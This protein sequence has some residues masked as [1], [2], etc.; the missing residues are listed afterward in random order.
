MSLTP[1]ALRNVIVFRF[2]TALLFRQH[3]TGNALFYT[4]RTCITVNGLTVC[5]KY[6]IR[7]LKEC[8]SRNSNSGGLSGEQLTVEPVPHTPGFCF[9]IFHFSF[10]KVPRSNFHILI[11]TVLIGVYCGTRTTWR[12]QILLYS[13]RQVE[14]LALVEPTG[15]LLFEGAMQG[16][17]GKLNE[18][19]GD[20]Y[21][22][23]IPPSGEKEFLELL[24]SKL[25][26][27][28]IRFDPTAPDGTFKVLYPMLGS[29]ALAA[30]IRSGDLI[31][32]VDG[33]NTENLDQLTLTKKIRGEPGTEVVLTV[34]HSGE[35]EPVEIPIRRTSIQQ[36]TVFGFEVNEQG[37]SIS[38][39]PGFP[40]I[41]YIYI[42][43]FTANTAEEMSRQIR[44]FRTVEKLILDLRDNP[45]GMLG[46]AVKVADLFV[47][48][49]GP[50]KEIVT[51]RNR[52]GQVKFGGTFYATENVLF[53]GP[54]VVLIDG[55]SAS[56]SE[57]VAACLQDFGR[58]NIL[59][60]RSFGKGTVQEI[61][62]LPLNTGLM[63]LT[64]ASYWRP[65]GKNINRVRRAA[66]IETGRN[67]QL[68]G[69]TDDW[70]VR[71]DPGLE[72]ETTRNQRVLTYFFRDMRIAIPKSTLS[73]LLPLY[74]EELCKDTSKLLQ[75]DF[76][77]TEEMEEDVGELKPFEPEGQSPF[78]D[79]VLDRAIEILANTAYRIH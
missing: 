23:Y 56:A 35:S 8:S 22:M 13:M 50:Y 11:L 33:E 20:D 58:A 39:I 36:K 64:D 14:S 63:K 43:A 19:L 10:E 38:E 79:P 15:Q 7:L 18:E 60:Q 44:S 16:M 12:E 28:G 68:S 6:E 61:F 69:E 17:L 76:D 21:S 57:I 49:R 48:H 52:A 32:K 45:G 55:G 66:K 42:S 77:E 67:S 62:Q 54:I 75:W 40:E 78:Y 72:L 9:L 51:T 5:W 34:Q 71:P 4:R 31:L 46:A 24:E 65:S 59:G 1:F 30:G 70:G 25:E 47:D 29:P 26:G 3:W 2:G 73:P 41:G 37:D 53:H 74:K 27:I